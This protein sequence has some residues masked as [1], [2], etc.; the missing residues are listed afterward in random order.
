MNGTRVI[1]WRSMRKPPM[2]GFCK[3][4]FA[5]GVTLAE[6]AVM[7]GP[8]GAYASPP[9]RPLLRSGVPVR[10]RQS[11]KLRYVVLIDFPNKEIR[12]Q[13]SDSIIAALREAYP[14]FDSETAEAFE[15]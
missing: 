6:V 5:S 9:T 11:G 12:N 2:I 1:E 8:H 10:D 14:D 13:W 7:H 4:Q 3:L 15:E